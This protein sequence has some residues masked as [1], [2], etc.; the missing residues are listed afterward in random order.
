MAGATFTITNLGGLGIDTFTPIITLPQAAV[1]GIG[2]IA[3]TDDAERPAHVSL[4][5]DHRVADGADAARFLGT[6]AER[7]AELVR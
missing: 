7:I 3:G 1:L 6:L 2:R 5:F 4:T